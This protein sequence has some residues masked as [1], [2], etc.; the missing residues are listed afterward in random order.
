MAKAYKTLTVSELI[1]ELAAARKVSTHTRCRSCAPVY[2]YGPKVLEGL[3]SLL[4]PCGQLREPYDC[5][6]ET[7]VAVQ[8]G[9]D[10]AA[11]RDP[12]CDPPPGPC[13]CRLK[14]LPPRDEH[15]ERCKA[16]MVRRQM[17]MDTMWASVDYP[18]MTE[19]AAAL[20]QPYFD[21][22]DKQA[23]A[24]KQLI[25]ALRKRGRDDDLKLAR[26]IEV[27]AWP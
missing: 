26:A 18:G 1:A 4:C 5:L 6:T 22:A 27:T 25:A 7:W 13:N 15:I 9:E 12:S 21:I 23:R 8:H 16:A 19:H 10:C 20:G 2:H 3:D 11:D 24:G 17:H 14:R